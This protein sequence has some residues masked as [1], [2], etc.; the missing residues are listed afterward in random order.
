M[1]PFKP[2]LPLPPKHTS[3]THTKAKNTQREK[4]K[5]GDEVQLTADLKNLTEL[6]PGGGVGNLLSG[7][8]GLSVLDLSR[9]LLVGSVPARFGLLRNLTLLDMSRNNFSGFIPPDFG[10]LM[11]LEVLNLCGNGMSSLVPPQLGDL[12]GLV[13]LDLSFNSFSGSIGMDLTLL[14]TSPALF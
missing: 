14:V 13:D 2:Y 3:K 4:L 9:N 8:E 5:Y 7:L 6:K 10:F 12:S 11:K 1:S